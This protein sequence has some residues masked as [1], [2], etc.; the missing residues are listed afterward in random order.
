MDKS[1]HIDQNFS[2]Q[3]LQLGKNA[4]E[5]STQVSGSVLSDTI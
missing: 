3:G 4:D 5:F 2:F 1:H